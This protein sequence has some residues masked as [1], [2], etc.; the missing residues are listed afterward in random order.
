MPASIRSLAPAPSSAGG[1]ASPGRPAA[2]SGTSR[3][4]SA[5]SASAGPPASNAGLA[6]GARPQQ[7]DDRGVGQP[8]LV[9]VAS[10][11]RDPRPAGPGVGRELVHQPRL[12]DPGLAADHREAP[13]AGRQ[14][15]GLAQRAALRLA[16]DQGQ[17]RRGGGG[18]GDRRGRR[19]G[20]GRQLALADGAVQRRRLGQGRHAELPVE[21]AHALAVLGQRRG[22]VAA[23]GVEA[24]ELA[25]GGLL[26]RV[27]AQAPARVPDGRREAARLREPLDEAVERGGQLAAQRIG[28]ERLPVVEVRA[29]AQRE[30]REEVVAVDGDGL[31][32][33]LGGGPRIGDARAEAVEVDVDR[34]AAEQGDPL[35]RGLQRLVA[36]RSPQRRQG[37]PQRPAGVAL[38]V[39][40]PQQRR[41]RVARAGAA[42]QRQVGQEGDGLAR[43]DLDGPPVDLDLRRPQEGDG[44]RGHRATISRRRILP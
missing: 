39:L 38:V 32:Q 23:Q 18:G 34:R 21:G 29:V 27:Q 7:A 6:L 44:Q 13:A 30:A 43:V 41:E 35:P 19:R 5:R 12:A 42:G 15:V 20:R 28:L 11:R 2:S 8:L 37:A 24:D 10:R 40:G 3:A 25:V 26:Q 16:A 33:R 4:A 14:P 17:L 1:G 36:D 31:L 9:L 22:A